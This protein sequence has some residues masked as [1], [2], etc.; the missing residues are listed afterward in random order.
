MEK[1]KNQEDKKNIETQ[2]K[3]LKLQDKTKNQIID[4]VSKNS[5]SIELH[6]EGGSLWKDIRDVYKFKDI[7]GG[8]H[9][10]TVRIGVQKNVDSKK[11]YAIKSISKKNITDKDFEE[12]IKEVEIL[13]KLDHPSIIKFYET[14]NDEYYFH[15]VMELAKG[16]D[17]FDKILDE[18][19]ITENT[20]CHIVYKVLSALLYCHCRGICHR[21]IKPEN[22][23]F[24]NESN[25]GEIKLIDFG[26]S[27]KYNAQEKMNTVLGTP[28]YVAPEVLQGSYDEKCDIWSVGAF[29]YIMLSGDPPFNGKN[30]NAIFKRILNEDV[31]YPED[32]FKNVSK[33]AMEFMKHCLVKNPVKR[34]TAEQALEHSW[35][36]NV[37]KEVHSSSKLDVKVFQNLKNFSFPDKFQKM[38]LKFLV[39]QIN[40]K[41]L[42]HLRE[43]FQAMDT[44]HTG[45]LNKDEVQ[46]GFKKL[47]IKISK[48]EV[49]EIILK[50]E[51]C[52]HGK[53]NYSEFLVAAMDFKSNVDKEKLI[54]AFSYFD[55]DKTGQISVED[56]ESS[57]L[58]SGKKVLNHE[59][60]TQV[61]KEATHGKEINKITL[62]EF[63]LMFGYK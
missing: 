47:G 31:T 58:R 63:L 34:W 8:G 59:E 44:H 26:L 61:I 52:E 35:F 50:I 13:S 62:D 4:L 33:E 21:D 22:I 30:N 11:K 20:V 37:S 5:G 60:I 17:V 16:K 18:K 14:Y 3:D 9:F 39:N 32:K 7:I 43:V 54:L 36:Q 38:V 40:E 49:E 25:E 12:M 10:G 45:S 57:L 28:Y 27:R 19:S 23:L 56:I 29:T 41:E 48:E 55:V 2:F 46:E 15:I 53:I 6:T 42:D 51:D 24:E 1:D